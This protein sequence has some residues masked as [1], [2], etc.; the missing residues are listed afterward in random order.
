MMTDESEQTRF[1]KEFQARLNRLMEARAKGWINCPMCEGMGDIF[2]RFTHVRGNC[3][4]CDGFGL[5]PFM[6]IVGINQKDD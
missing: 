1:Q 6:N 4:L 3:P 2:N 5:V